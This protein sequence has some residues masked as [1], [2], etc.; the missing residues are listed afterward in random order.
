MVGAVVEVE[1]GTVLQVDAGTAAHADG[2]LGYPDVDTSVGPS[3]H[4][5]AA[6]LVEHEVYLGQCT[7]VALHGI[8]IDDFHRHGELGVHGHAEAADAE[9][10]GTTG[11]SGCLEGDAAVKEVDFKLACLAVDVSDAADEAFDAHEGRG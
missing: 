5:Q 11:G 10:D 8:G 6:L 1:H 4:L 9:A 3:A 7:D 2:G